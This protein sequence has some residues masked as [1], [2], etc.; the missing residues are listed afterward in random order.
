[1]EI[2]HRSPSVLPSTNVHR[3]GLA[4]QV[5]ED[6]R[7][8][9]IS[10]EWADGEKL[11]TESEL[12]EYYG[13]SR[14]TVREALKSLESE[15]RILTQQGRG[16]FAIGYSGIGAGMQELKS[17][18]STVREMGHVPSMIYHH[19]VWREATP[20]EVEKFDLSDD[21]IV[22]DIQRKLL[23]DGIAVCYNYDVLP[24]WVFPSG[25]EPAHLE[26]SVF[27]FLREH[28]GPTPK[29]ALARIKPVV[30]PDVVWDSEFPPDQLFLSLDQLHYDK[31][32]RPFMHTQAYFVDGRFNFTVMRTATS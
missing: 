18:T 20:E 29:R 23:A 21:Q 7:A 3:Q 11:P 26:G 5:K 25:F 27:G 15:G 13:V 16:S 22:L 9:L 30:Q 14:P 24:R 2:E 8:R 32:G 1:M 17:I 6:L 12:V 28:G 10:N 4:A 19:R 31:R